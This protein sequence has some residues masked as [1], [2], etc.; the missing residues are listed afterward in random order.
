MMVDEFRMQGSIIRVEGTIGP[1]GG[2]EAIHGAPVAADSFL[3]KLELS[4]EDTRGG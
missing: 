4:L 1:P 3:L 2:R